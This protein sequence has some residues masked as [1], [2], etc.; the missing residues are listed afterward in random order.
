MN[1]EIL[2]FHQ[3]HHV[4]LLQLKAAAG[5]AFP[6]LSSTAAMRSRSIVVTEK[7]PEPSV[8]EV[9]VE[10]RS[11][12]HVF[13]LDGDILAGAKQDRVV[14][15]SMVLPPNSTTP[16]PVSCLEHGRWSRAYA[17]FSKSPHAAPSFL[18]AKK[19]AAVSHTAQSAKHFMGYQAEVWDD[20]A[21]YHRQFRHLSRTGNLNDLYGTFGKDLQAS[22]KYFGRNKDANG[23][24]FFIGGRVASVDVFN[25]ADLC[26][27]YF[28]ALLHAALLEGVRWHGERVDLS[29][30][31]AE[32][33]LH[34]I[35]VE[36]KET[37]PRTYPGI[38]IGTQHRWVT[39]THAAVQLR[40]KDSVI[41]YTVASSS[42]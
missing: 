25:N 14:N 29:A 11:N 32:S 39:N 4:A 5:P 35:I 18:R 6:C 36:L 13:F 15:T 41:H 24:A 2:T 42:R 3:S 7:Q 10:N 1:L 27:E 23:L 33:F 38:G 34:A 22:A 40:C 21:T 26:G 30:Q 17:D 28:E 31:S 12:Q 8:N 37:K 9:V 19:A 20:V 16:I